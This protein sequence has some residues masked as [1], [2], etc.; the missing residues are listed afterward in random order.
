MKVNT[1]THI[2]TF[3]S[4]EALKLY[5]VATG[6]YLKFKIWVE[7]PPTHMSQEQKPHSPSTHTLHL[8]LLHS[9]TFHLGALGPQFISHQ[10]PLTPL[11]LYLILKQ[12]DRVSWP[13][14][15][16]HTFLLLEFMWIWAPKRYLVGLV[17]SESWFGY[18]TVQNRG[19]GHRI[20]SQSIA[21]I[22]FILL[23]IIQKKEI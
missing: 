23:Q 10:L 21:V 14:L 4:N 2:I 12:T 6:K 9:Y 13:L 17:E 15:L 8:W 22:V 1:N 11:L 18:Q 20:V 19:H 5:R 16:I 3:L 7:N